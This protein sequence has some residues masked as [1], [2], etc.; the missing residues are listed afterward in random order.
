MEIL[1]WGILY[2]ALMG[3]PLLIAGILF[4]EVFDEK[5]ELNRRGESDTRYRG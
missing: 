3:W 2:F 4:S 5:R 1:F